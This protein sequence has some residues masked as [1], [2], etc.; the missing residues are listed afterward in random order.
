MNEREIRSL[1]Q[2]AENNG[3]H[4]KAEMLRELADTIELYEP[5]VEAVRAELSEGEYDRERV[6]N[7]I[8]EADSE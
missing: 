2:F 6:E 1:A 8:A 5:V 4:T 3:A 7:Y